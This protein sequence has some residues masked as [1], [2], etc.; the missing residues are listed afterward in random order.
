[1]ERIAR[2]EA[3]LGTL[4]CSQ[5][6]EERVADAVCPSAEL[7]GTAPNSVHNSVATATTAVDKS[8]SPADSNASP[9]TEASGLASPHLALAQLKAL[10]D[11]GHGSVDWRLATPQMAKS[12]SQ[13]LC[14]AFFTSCCV[15]LP[16]FSYYRVKM[17]QY[18]DGLDLPDSTKVRSWWSIHG[19]RALS[20]TCETAQVAI[21]AFCAVGARASPH[22]VSFLRRIQVMAPSLTPFDDHQQA[23]LGIEASPS[24]AHDHPQAP[25]VSA[26]A[27]RHSA[28]AV[29]LQ[30]AHSLSF[31][32]GL[33]DEPTVDN[34]AGILALMQ[35][36]M[37]AELQ[38]KKS[39]A[40]LRAAVG[41]Y[42]EL[43]D[44][45]GDRDEADEVQ[46][47]FGLAVYVGL[48]S[49]PRCKLLSLTLLFSVQTADALSSAYARRSPLL[50]DAD[51]A[52][53]FARAGIVVP[54]LPGDD[55][56]A[57][58]RVLLDNPASRKPN[59]KTALHLITCWTAAC[60]R[61][62]AKLAAREWCR[63]LQ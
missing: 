49:A 13:H 21:A 15:L 37:F 9:S 59:L 23:V 1:M 47:Q 22:S 7:E 53:Y 17:P 25:L 39:R 18:K 57:I 10:G 55:L 58:L 4:Y 34:L 6:T 33:M 46:K 11:I 54:T 41:H 3:R 8:P 28:C 5:H 36:I 31:E 14:D 12:L 56:V 30:Q 48:R 32:H 29:L 16:A 63:L 35:M 24:D 42:K 51:V 26:G 50:T 45:A 43:Q 60:Q 61:I 20:L 62:F 2:L 40:L 19:E 27:R 52:Q 44:A 38:P